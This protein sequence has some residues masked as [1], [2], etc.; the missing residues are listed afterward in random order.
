MSDT[1]TVVTFGSHALQ[2][3]RAELWAA[4]DAGAAIHLVN[5]TSGVHRGWL[6]AECEP[7]Y[8]PVR[9]GCR[10]LGAHMGQLLE[11]VRSGTTFE[12]YDH[13]TSQVRGYLT[14]CPPRVIAEDP[15]ASLSYH[16]KRRQGKLTRMLRA[17][18]P[19]AVATRAVEAVAP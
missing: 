5:L 10:Q 13:Q 7:G 16:L 8:E 19:T 17:E 3:Q 18:F 4:L 9:I 1:L 11:D 15:E 12:V 6:T 14:W 2:A